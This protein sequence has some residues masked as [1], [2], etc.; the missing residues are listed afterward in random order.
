MFQRETGWLEEKTLTKIRVIIKE[1]IEYALGQASNNS[2]PVSPPSIAQD[3]AHTPKTVV[4]TNIQI[5]VS[6][7]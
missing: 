3:S 4:I 5:F 6:T 7:K 1:A 2:K